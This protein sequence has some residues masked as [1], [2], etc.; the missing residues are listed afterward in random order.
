MYFMQSLGHDSLHLLQ[1]MH[2]A[3]KSFSFREPGGLTNR[4][5]NFDC[6]AFATIGN[7]IAAVVVAVILFMKNLLFIRSK[8]ANFFDLSR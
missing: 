3:R 7:A 8:L 1:R 2:R 6:T 5:L 4:N